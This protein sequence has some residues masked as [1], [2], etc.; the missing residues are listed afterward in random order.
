[1]QNHNLNFATYKIKIFL[2]LNVPFQVK[3]PI[4]SLCHHLQLNSGILFKG[5]H[6]KWHFPGQTIFEKEDLSYFE[7][8]VV[9]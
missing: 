1:M 2:I 3:I 8:K 6:F 4:K 9:T 5:I 7:I